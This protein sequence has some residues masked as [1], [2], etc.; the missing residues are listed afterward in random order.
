[1]RLALVRLDGVDKAKVS[2]RKQRAWAV[3]EPEKVTVQQMI[4][5]VARSGFGAEAVP[6]GGG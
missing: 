5:A 4:D 3:Y 1:M 2:F 6:D